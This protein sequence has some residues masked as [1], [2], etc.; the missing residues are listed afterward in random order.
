MKKVII[1]L[2]LLVVIFLQVTGC[3]NAKI[4]STE[5]NTEKSKSDIIEIAYKSLNEGIQKNSIINWKSAKVEEY[6]SQLDHLIG[7][8]SGEV[9]IKDKDTYKI[10]FETDNDM[11]LGSIIVYLDRNSYTALGIDFRE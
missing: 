7:S 10:T 2:C 9:N 4:K 8:Q 6:K 5:I 11:L 3:T 1:S